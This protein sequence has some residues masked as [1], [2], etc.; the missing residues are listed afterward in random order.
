[1]T[2]KTTITPVLL[3]IEKHIESVEQEFDLIKDDITDRFMLNEFENIDETDVRKIIDSNGRKLIMT[4]PAMCDCI[5]SRFH[6]LLLRKKIVKEKGYNSY[7][8]VKCTYY[9]FEA[10]IENLT[11]ILKNKQKALKDWYG[12]CLCQH[13]QPNDCKYLDEHKCICEL[14]G[15][16]FE[17]CRAN[18]HDCICAKYPSENVCLEHNILVKSAVFQ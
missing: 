9:Q 12:R 14:N 6:I 1:M 18:N 7:E 16:M 8:Y 5:R 11:N 17:K 4:I 10:V 13:F 3:F 2:K 15:R